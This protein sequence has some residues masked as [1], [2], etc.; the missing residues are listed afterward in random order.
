MKK[1]TSMVITLLF[2]AACQHG[3]SSKSDSYSSY[4]GSSSGRMIATNSA[5]RIFI[6]E[7]ASRSKTLSMRTIETQALKYIKKYDPSKKAG[8]WQQMGLS[9]QQAQKINSLYDD[10]PYMNKVRKWLRSNITK[11]VRVER[12]IA[13]Q[14]FDVMMKGRKSYLNPYKFHASQTST[15]VTSRRSSLSPFSS[16]SEH[17]SRV[18]HNITKLP[19]NTT[20][21][22][23]STAKQIKNLQTRYKENL[24]TM[25]KRGKTN[26][27]LLANGN[28]IVDSAAKITKKTG[29]SGM[30]PGCKKFNESAADNIIANKADIDNLRAQIIEERAYAKAGKSFGSFDEIPAAK[31]LTQGEVDDAT[32]EAFK[33]VNAMTDDEARAA[34][35][36]LKQKPCRLY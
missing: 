14:A 36:R 2:V 11:V 15:R 26:P 29:H 7:L 30:G 24:L 18:T 21:V 35:N 28:E 17:Q 3:P 23:S 32:V 8:N 5:M 16:I 9:K 6:Q 10:L 27:S 13:E 4:T 25:V 34:L 19:T 22:G 1:I 33:R 31:R 12:Q 20:K